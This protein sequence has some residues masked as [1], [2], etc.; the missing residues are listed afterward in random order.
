MLC[1]KVC[2]NIALNGDRFS[3]T[4]NCTLGVIGLSWIGN[5]TT[6]RE[7][8]EAPLNLD[9]IR[10]G[11]SRLEGINPIYLIIDTCKRSVE[12]PGSTKIRL[13]L[14]S[15]IPSVKIRA[16]RCCCNIRVRSTKG[17]R[18]TSSIG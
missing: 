16:S 10:P 15:S 8:V 2:S 6:P 18:I 12:L 3:T 9:N 7:V 13:T 1:N 11:F 4:E 14:K 17:K 5:M